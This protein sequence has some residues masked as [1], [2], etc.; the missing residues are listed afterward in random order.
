MKIVGNQNTINSI[1][2]A[3]EII[4]QKNEEQQQKEEKK[5]K[6]KPVQTRQ[7]KEGKRRC[8]PDELIKVEI[9]LTPRQYRVWLERGGEKYFRRI[10]NGQ[11]RSQF[12][13]KK[14]YKKVQEENERKRKEKLKEEEQKELLEIQELAEQRRREMEENG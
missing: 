11:Y 12:V 6:K 14:N 1:Q 8:N 2:K 5:K 3:A 4:K 7:M 13:Y 10:I 9:L